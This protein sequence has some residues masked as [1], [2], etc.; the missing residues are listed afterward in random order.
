[1]VDLGKKRNKA[2]TYTLNPLGKGRK[3]DLAFKIYE[4]MKTVGHM[5]DVYTMQALLNGLNSTYQFARSLSSL[6]SM[7]ASRNSEMD[8]ESYNV[9]SLS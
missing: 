6:D 5:T 8:T 1:M 7:K 9:A 2:T 3:E 4:H